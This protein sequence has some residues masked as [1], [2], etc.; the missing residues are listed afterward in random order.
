MKKKLMIVLPI[1]LLVAGGAFM[2]L[3]PLGAKTKKPIPKVKGVV[4]ELGTGFVVNLAGT[5]YG[6]VSVGLV[7]KALP[8][9]AAPGAAPA[10]PEDAAVRAV[11]TDEL[12]GLPEA[13]LIDR[14]RRHRLVARLL[15]ALKAR[16]D[17]PIEGVLLTDIAVE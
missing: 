17:E 10:L 1:V 13:D 12:T 5:H 15:R 11:I 2:K 8:P 16:T 7:M 4:F 6:K 14:T 3:H 9:S